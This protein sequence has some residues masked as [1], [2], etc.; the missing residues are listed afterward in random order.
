MP[1][2][3]FKLQ[4]PGVSPPIEPLVLRDFNGDFG[5]PRRSRVGISVA[6]TPSNLGVTPIT[7]PAYNYK[8]V[9]SCAFNLSPENRR[10]LKAL[11]NWQ[12]RTVKAKQDGALLLT[13]ELHELDPE[14]SPHSKT[15][16]SGTSQAW[17]GGSGYVY[18]YGQFLVKLEPGD[19][20][21]Q[22]IN[23]IGSEVLTFRLV[24]L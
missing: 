7:G 15:I 24:E 17:S 2:G 20:F 12:D 6:S 8:Y 5:W 23:W 4:I 18:G 1:F 22:R 9:W 19:D 16:A 3:E 10:H 21:E 14:P 13:D 11:A